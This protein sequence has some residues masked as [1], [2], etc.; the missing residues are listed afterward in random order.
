MFFHGVLLNSYGFVLMFYC[1]VDAVCCF[2]FWSCIILIFV[3]LVYCCVVMV[4]LY[5]AL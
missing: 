4:Y 1:D 2:S 5:F 3:A